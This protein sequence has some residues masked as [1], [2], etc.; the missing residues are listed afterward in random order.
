MAR[1][2]CC[3]LNEY[4]KVVRI[5]ELDSYDDPDA[6]RDVMFLM[7]RTGQFSGYEL[8]RDGRKVDEWTSVRRGARKP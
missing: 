4:D 8:W 3:F 5:E 1:Y 6:H 7:A 2:R